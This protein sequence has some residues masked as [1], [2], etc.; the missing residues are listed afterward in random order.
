[1]PLVRLM[2]VSALEYIRFRQILLYKDV[3][4]GRRDQRTLTRLKLRL[5]YAKAAKL[6]LILVNGEDCSCIFA[7]TPKIFVYQSSLVYI[8]RWLTVGPPCHIQKSLK[9]YF[10]SRPW[11]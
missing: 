3:K 4:R 8:K 1:M 2:Q 5:F 11:L 7:N 6:V 9:H 10:Q